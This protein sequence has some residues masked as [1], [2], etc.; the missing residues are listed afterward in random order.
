MGVYVRTPCCSAVVRR[1]LVAGVCGCV[2]ALVVRT[3][4]RVGGRMHVHRAAGVHASEHG[5]VDT[6][7]T[8]FG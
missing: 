2:R 5:H 7:S 4:A 6:E 8:G 3:R 1:A